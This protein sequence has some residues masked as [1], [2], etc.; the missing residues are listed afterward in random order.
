[1]LKS[2]SIP[3]ASV[4]CDE[5]TDLCE[6]QHIGIFPTI[7]AYKGSAENRELYNGKRTVEDMVA[8]VNRLNRP[9]VS[10]LKSVESVEEF[11]TEDLITVVG[12]FHSGDKA[13]IE[14]FATVAKEHKD[15]YSFGIAKDISLAEAENVGQPSIV[16]FKN[17]DDGKDIYT[18][19]YDEASITKFLDQ[20]ARPIIGSLGPET[21]GTYKG[22]PIAFILAET[23]A[24]RD[25]LAKTLRPIA[26]AHKKE[27]GIVTADPEV[28]SQLAINMHLKGGFPNFAI[29]GVVETDRYPFTAGGSVSALN[30]KDIGQFVE[31]FLAGN[32]KPLVVPI[33]PV[34]V[35]TNSNATA[36]INDDAKDVLVE[37][38]APW[39]GHCQKLAPI[40]DNLALEFKTAEGLVT[41]AKMDATENKAPE[42]VKSYP[43][44]M[45]YK[46]GDKA[47]PIVYSGDRSLKDLATFVRDN[48]AHKANIETVRDEL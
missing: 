7:K 46:V 17:F 42:Q 15:A 2:K 41:I 44:L 29:T 38:Y 13:S 12:Y 25:L 31:D 16:L 32:L 43:T 8:Y 4:N 6:E 39:C 9:R 36:I 37:Y 23:Q 10:L 5:N 34:A 33:S 1:M 40:Y 3:F 45:L 24:E 14:V 20:S 30:P 21:E 19:S 18:G 48:G 47:N 11:K 35:L 28:Y 27:I 26:E 22:M